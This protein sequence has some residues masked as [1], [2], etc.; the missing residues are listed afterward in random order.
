MLAPAGVQGAQPPR[1]T[2]KGVYIYINMYINIHILRNCQSLTC[3]S[4]KNIR[5]CQSLIG[6]DKFLILCRDSIVTGVYG[7][8]GG[9]RSGETGVVGE[10]WRRRVN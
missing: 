2:K 1:K 4:L 9:L 10:R 5:N 6:I 3:A 8:M 7:G